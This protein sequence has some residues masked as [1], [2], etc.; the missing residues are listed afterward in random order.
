M[1][2]VLTQS[3][4][5]KL[6]GMIGRRPTDGEL[7]M[8]HFMGVGGAAKLIT[9]ARQSAGLRCAVVS[10]CRCGEPFDLFRPQ[11]ARPQRF[12]GLFG[13]MTRYASAANSPR[14]APRWPRWA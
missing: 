4:S 11:R 8:A 14:R 10:E 6:T 2:A 13:L 5:F 9:N 3:N 12:R 1:A 7:Y